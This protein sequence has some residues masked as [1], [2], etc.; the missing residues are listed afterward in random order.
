MVPADAWVDA[1]ASAAAVAA[2]V[3]A[4]AAID[5]ATAVASCIAAATANLP[6]TAAGSAAAANRAAA[7]AVNA[8]VV[9]AD[10]ADTA[11]AAAAAAASSVTMSTATAAAASSSAAAAA[12][13]AAALT[14]ATTASGSARDAADL[15]HCWDAETEPDFWRRLVGLRRHQHR[16]SGGAQDVQC[17]FEFEEAL[18]AQR[19]SGD[20]AGCIVFLGNDGVAAIS[21]QRLRRVL[22]ARG[23]TPLSYAIAQGDTRL[24]L[25]FRK[26]PGVAWS[27][28]REPLLHQVIRAW[29]AAHIV[30]SRLQD[31]VQLVLLPVLWGHAETAKNWDGKA[32]MELTASKGWLPGLLHIVDAMAASA[33]V[34]DGP[35]ATV[36]LTAIG[37]CAAQGKL[38]HLEDGSPGA[39]E[40]L[41]ELLTQTDSGM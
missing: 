27:D 32:A 4:A 35:S 8:A 33:T 25:L 21:D 6:Y 11:A 15:V 29:P 16:R 34:P 30:G 31:M 22:P 36:I 2:A 7:A 39:T 1:A 24:A 40:R 13:A 20:A 9:A 5:A 10:G 28:T 3:A 41:F 12:S 18:E 38:Q 19:N 23:D 26:Y 17:C 37:S 14:A